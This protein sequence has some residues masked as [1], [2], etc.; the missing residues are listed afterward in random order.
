MS[1][2]NVSLTAGT[3]ASAQTTAGNGQVM[4]TEPGNPFLLSAY[5]IPV[6][7]VLNQLVNFL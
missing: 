2:A 7:F 5:G 4:Q 1:S 3:T 6:N